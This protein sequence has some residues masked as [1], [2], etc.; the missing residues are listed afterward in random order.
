MAALR[1]A[2]RVNVLPKHMLFCRRLEGTTRSDGSAQKGVE[3]DVEK[4]AEKKKGS[5]AEAFLKFQEIEAGN[6]KTVAEQRFT[7]LLR[8]SKWVQ[9]GD[10][11][12]KIVIGKIFHIV[13]D[14]LYIDFGGKFHCVCRRPARNSSDYTRGTKVRLRLN[15]LEMS[16]RFLGA[17]KD[18]TLLEADAT[19]LGIARPTTVQSSKS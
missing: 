9:L 3:G 5:F 13:E 7:T 11:D 8:N 12:K 2:F 19:L 10:A 18:L 17:D 16:S 15:D 14:D 6:G 1:C 4:T